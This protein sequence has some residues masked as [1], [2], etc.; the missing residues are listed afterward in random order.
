MLLV[1]EVSRR[2]IAGAWQER[3]WREQD[4]CFVSGASIFFFFFYSCIV[5]RKHFLLHQ[6]VHV[7]PLG[8]SVRRRGTTDGMVM[9]VEC[10][11][12][13]STPIIFTV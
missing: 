1:Q 10:T 5:V 13:G 7:S 3:M 4:E 12:E 11:Q 6:M 9:R 2:E 8:S